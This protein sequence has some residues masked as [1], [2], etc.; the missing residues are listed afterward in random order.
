MP[1]QI[2]EVASSVGLH[3]RPASIFV[4][5]VVKTGLQIKIGKPGNA[6]L[7]AASLLSVLALGIK[8]GEKVEIVVPDD[9][10]DAEL[11]LDE[12]VK[13]IT[14]NFDEIK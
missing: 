5:S 7:N 6:S 1:S 2:V 8:C 11:V 13:I 12:L 10:P 4:K 9:A 14:T 3:A